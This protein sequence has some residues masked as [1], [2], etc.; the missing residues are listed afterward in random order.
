MCLFQGL[1]SWTCC[2]IVR[3]PISDLLS[4]KESPEQILQHADSC[5]VESKSNVNSTSLISWLILYYCLHTLSEYLMCAGWNV[6]V[7]QHGGNLSFIR[8]WNFWSWCW[9]YW[10]YQHS[11]FKSLQSYKGWRK[12]TTRNHW[13]V[14]GKWFF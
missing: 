13:L 4:Q 8:K 11:C 1:S 12:G 6:C 7:S 5:N 10:E 14:E 2:R 3:A 9:E